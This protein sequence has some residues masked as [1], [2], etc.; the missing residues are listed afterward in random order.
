[1]TRS[2]GLD[3]SH[4]DGKW[5]ANKAAKA[6]VSFIYTKATQQVVDSTYYANMAAAKSAGILRG[7][8]HFWDWRMSDTAQANLFISTIKADPGELPPM[9][10]YEMDPTPYGITKSLA[11]GRLWNMV[12]AV[13]KALGVTPG[14]Y[15]GFYFWAD[16]GSTNA[17][18]SVFPLWEAWWEPE[19][20]VKVPPPWS[21]WKIWQY[22]GKGYGPDYGAEALGIDLDYFNG[23]V[24]DLKAWAHVAPAPA[25][26]R[27]PSCGAVMP[28]GWSYQKP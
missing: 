25:V 10:D 6:G 8:F 26:L 17:G 16:W 12:S 27:C 18:W 9:I 5:D 11:Q 1:M 14:I 4:G 22:S 24:D 28:P 3:L 7:S 19:N 21:A 23:T 20:V 2:F 15:T 13:Q